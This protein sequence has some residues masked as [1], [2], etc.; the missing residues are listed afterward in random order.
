[1]PSDLPVACTLGPDALSAR[2]E[3]LLSELCR[4]AHAHE[5]LADGHRL[6]FAATDETLALIMKVV[7]LERRCCRFLRFRITVEPDGGPVSVDL[8]GPSGT[9]EFLSALFDS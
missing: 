7:A 5:E 8:T 2:R 6:S 9:R 3:G 1:M 4:R